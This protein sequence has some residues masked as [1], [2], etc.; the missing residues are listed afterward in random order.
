M[1]RTDIAGALPRVS[2]ALAGAGEL[3]Q[4]QSL[5]VEILD[6]AEDVLALER[7]WR[8]LED[9]C[10]NT[11]LFQ[12]FAWCANHMAFSASR[13]DFRPCVLALRHNLELVGLL[14]LCVR[15]VH[16]IRCAT[17][18]CEPFQLYTE[19]LL[20]PGIAPVEA[21]DAVAS[22]LRNLPADYLHLGQVRDDGPLAQC[23]RHLRSRAVEGDVAPFV[24]LT[25][26]PDFD[27]FLK[28]RNAKTRKN[29]RNATNRLKRDG[30]LTHRIAAAAQERREIIER[31]HAGREAWLQR[32]GLTSR[33]FREE[34]FSEFL[35]R[36][37]DARATGVE[38]L[39]MTLEHCGKP[40]ADQW[41]FVYHGCYY[42]FMATWDVEYESF[43]P[44][45]LHLGEVIRTCF[46]RQLAVADFM[47]P[48]VAYKFTWTESAAPVRDHVLVLRLRGHLQVHLWLGLL[49]P[50]AKRVFGII[51][52]R[53]RG[54]LVKR[55]LPLLE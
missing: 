54:I 36:F 44:G 9:Q 42:A 40:I 18:L 39:A 15:N 49:R 34:N 29:L 41:G 17:G 13:S 22:V 43:S 12:S 55:V 25:A 21:A 1:F 53:L 26:W 24:D 23:L 32:L 45:R 33:A 52:A 11:A 47:I 31:C 46:D 3:V 16:G 38:I 10:A 8:A 5:A 37:A 28:S 50:A 20:A 27:G 14:P 7:D 19:L 51:P 30:P 35:A 4:A 6:R 2:G 48:G